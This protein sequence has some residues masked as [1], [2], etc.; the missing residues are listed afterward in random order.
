MGKKECYAAA[1]A[2]TTNVYKALFLLQF[3][4]NMEPVKDTVPL[5][6]LKK[7]IRLKKLKK[8]LL[9]K[10]NCDDSSRSNFCLP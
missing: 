6:S 3:S 2:T 7:K 8:E 1:A 10:L 5:S 4:I 9:E